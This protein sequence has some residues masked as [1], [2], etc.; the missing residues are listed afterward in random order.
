[1]P[2]LNKLQPELLKALGKSRDFEEQYE[3]LRAKSKSES[4]RDNQDAIKY[5]DDVIK[6]YKLIK[7]TSPSSSDLKVQRD[8]YLQLLKEH[9]A[10]VSVL[11]FSKPE[12][13]ASRLNELDFDSDTIDKMTKGLE[14]AGNDED[15]CIAL[16]SS[17]I[18]SEITLESCAR[19]EH[20]HPSRR[21]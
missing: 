3:V 15:T 2:I 21:Y 12:D 14:Q 17:L 6:R 16:L 20:G 7:G 11:S 18:I 4:L 8:T 19:N 10:E 5:V 9:A 13:V 1:M